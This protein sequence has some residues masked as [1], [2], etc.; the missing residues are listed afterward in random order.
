L[1]GPVAEAE[2]EK[3]SIT[4][5]EQT[6][7]NTDA[8][9]RVYLD[10]VS[11]EGRMMDPRDTTKVQDRLMSPPLISRQREIVGAN[12]NRH[13]PGRRASSAGPRVRIRFPPAGSLSQR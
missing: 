3:Q 11:I 10:Q 1:D 4:D 5:F 7:G 9:I 2:F 12:V 8:K 6:I 13:R